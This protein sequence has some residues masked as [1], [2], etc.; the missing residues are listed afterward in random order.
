MPSSEYLV[1]SALLLIL[2][3]TIGSR[4]SPKSHLAK[5][6]LTAELNESRD[7]TEPE[8]LDKFQIMKKFNN[9]TWER[10][11]YNAFAAKLGDKEKIFPCIYA[12]KGYR[13]NDLLYLFLP[14]EDITERRNVLTAARAILAYVPNS[15]KYGLNTSLVFLT[16]NSDKKRNVEDYHKL[17]WTFL[18]SL[19]QLDPKPW[20]PNISEETMTNRWCFCFDGK[21]AFLAVLTPAHEKRKSRHL[22]NFCFVYQPRWVFELLLTTDA[23]REAA[24]KNVRALIDKYDY[25]L[26]HSPDISNFGDE[27]C[28]EAK[29][30]FIYD[31]NRPAV[32]PWPTL[33]AP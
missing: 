27:G 6:S 14:S 28:T 1:L 4:L 32:S 18:K 11:A 12:S 10:K 24:L 23:K 15:H 13:D 5:K 3:I 22:P 9:D 8:I 25:P 21:P 31:E 29:E 33:L 26:V 19:R 2:G 16:P 30:Y 17:F 20:P 7:S